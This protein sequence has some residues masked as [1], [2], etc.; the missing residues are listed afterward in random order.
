MKIGVPKWVR[1]C[2]LLQ[3]CDGG[4]S[5]LFLSTLLRGARYRIRSAVMGSF[6]GG[7]GI[8]EAFSMA[9]FRVP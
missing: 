9:R 2:G 1:R 3:P 4:S 7:S 8:L 6:G 5:S